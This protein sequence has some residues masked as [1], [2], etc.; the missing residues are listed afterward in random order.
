MFNFFLGN[1]EKLLY[2]LQIAKA[3]LHKKNKTA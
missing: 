1:S 2:A 3:Y